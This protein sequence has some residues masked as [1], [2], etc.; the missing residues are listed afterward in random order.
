MLTRWLNNIFGIRS[1][2]Q[3]YMDLLAERLAE[4]YKVMDESWGTDDEP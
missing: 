1:P 2:S 4:M 3:L